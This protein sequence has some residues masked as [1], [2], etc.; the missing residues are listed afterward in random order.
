MELP[1]TETTIYVASIFAG[2]LITLRAIEAG[3]EKMLEELDSGFERVWLFDYRGVY[4]D[5][6]GK[7]PA[8]FGERFSLLE[9]FHFP[10]IELRLYN[11][12]GS[13]R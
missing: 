1:P 4:L 7:I 11:I 5:P 9:E 3:I 10:G 2:I 12:P 8:A 6:E 13:A